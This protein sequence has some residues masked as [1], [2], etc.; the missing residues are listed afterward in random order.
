MQFFPPAGAFVGAGVAGGVAAD[1]WVVPVGNVDRAVGGDADVIGTEPLVAA[2]HQL[3][4][5]RFEASAGVGVGLFLEGQRFIRADRLEEP[6]GRLDA[7]P[8][9]ICA[10]DIGPGIA[11]QK[12]VA[13]RL[14]EQIALVDAD[15]A[16]RAGAGV[17]QVGH[18]ARPAQMPVLLGL[19]LVGEGG[20]V[21]L[22]VAAPVRAKR[23]SVSVPPW[24]NS[25]WGGT[26]A[27]SFSGMSPMP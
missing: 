22:G 17:Q 12:R 1:A 24:W 5:R 8:R 20:F 14:G 18:D 25:L 27:I 13:I 21:L 26:K 11:V 2:F 6:G 15:A 16:G 7:R 3:N 10:D 19:G 23:L 9:D 4:R